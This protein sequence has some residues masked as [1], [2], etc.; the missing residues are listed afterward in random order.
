MTSMTQEFKI[1]KKNRIFSYYWLLLNSSHIIQLLYTLSKY[2]SNLIGSEWTFS[3][4]QIK[5]SE[6]R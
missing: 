5:F 1:K 2:Y 3:G 6:K 4:S